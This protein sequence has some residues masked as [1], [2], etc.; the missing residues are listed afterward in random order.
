M[1]ALRP[2][3]VTRLEDIAWRAFIELDL[4]FGDV[5]GYE[6]F[7]KV[8]A[9]VNEQQYSPVTLTRISLAVEE[10]CYDLVQFNEWMSH[11]HTNFQRIERLAAHS[12]VRQLRV[13]IGLTPRFAPPV[14]SYIF[15]GRFCRNVDELP[16]TLLQI[17]RPKTRDHVV[18]LWGRKDGKFVMIRIE[19]DS[20]VYEL[21]GR[22]DSH[23]R[24][25]FR[26]LGKEPA[27]ITV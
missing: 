7:D 10:G 14:G 23:A 3:D 18:D 11:A 8:L 12:I 9:F 15:L 26:R 25:A 2:S 5:L 17:A 16:L 27:P 22:L 24:E 13:M 21:A 4:G 6:T 19:G 1:S 20:R